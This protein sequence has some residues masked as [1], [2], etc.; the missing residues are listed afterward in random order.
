MRPQLLVG[1]L[2][3][4]I[5]GL[6]FYVLELPLVYFWSIPFGIG[7]TIMIIASFFLPETSGPL[8]PPEG[9]RFCVFCSNPVPLNSDR[10][11]HCNGI[12][13]KGTT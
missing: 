13:P 9:F 11:P 1:G 5:L 6:G 7:G 2:F 3:V 4:G 10:C 12:Q 8:V